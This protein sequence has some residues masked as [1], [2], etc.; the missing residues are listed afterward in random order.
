MDTIPE[1]PTASAGPVLRLFKI[2]K[3]FPGLVANDSVDF[4]LLPGE[5]HALLGENGAGKSTLMHVVTGIYQPDSGQIIFDGAVSNFR[6]PAQ[7]IAAGIG[8]VHQHFKLIRAFTVAENIHLGWNETPPRISAKVL[9]A[10]TRA[11]AD[12]FNLDVSPDARVEQLSAGEQQRVEILRVLSRRARVLILDEPTAVLTPAEARHLFRA[13]RNFAASGNSVVFISH[14]LDEVLEISDRITVLRAGRKIA[15]KLAADC[16]SA[17]LATL[18]VGSEIA[19]PEKPL[20]VGSRHAKVALELANVCCFAEKGSSALRGISL[21]LHEGEILGVAGVAGNGQ[22]ELSE[23]LTG[24]RP[25]S[26]GQLRIAGRPVTSA[27]PAAFAAAG[28]GHIPEDRLR[29][30]LVPSMSVADNAVMREYVRSP[31]S[32][33]PLLFPSAAARLAREIIKDA[34]VVVANER[35][36]VRKLSGGNQQRLV[37]RR[38]MRIA[39]RALI[40]AYPTRGLDVGA[41][42]V[43]LRYLIAM[44]NAGVAVLVISEELEEVLSIADRLVVLFK[45]G[46]VGAFAA[47]EVNLQRIGLMMGGKNDQLPVF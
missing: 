25:I 31:I 22:R 5:V 46:I 4:D 7:A 38:E 28:I 43:V 18:M 19:M 14:K 29:T 20:T 2:T 3:T 24:I 17:M 9:R 23:V 44:R 47:G 40:A 45:G 26:K 35:M 21:K 1:Q 42:N 34:D 41:V 15:T 10:R 16:T 27:D 13:L 36:P 6:S 12:K 11:L 37:A 32:R 33:G 39:T 8:M 30:A